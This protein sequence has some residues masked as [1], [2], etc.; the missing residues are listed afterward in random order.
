M[1]KRTVLR[2]GA[3]VLLLALLAGCGTRESVTVLREWEPAGGEE[4]VASLGA[5]LPRIGMVADVGGIDDESFN[6]GAW[7]GLL[8]LEK[9]TGAPVEY[10]TSESAED[11]QGNFE[12]LIAAG[13]RLTWGIGYEFSDTV[14]GEAVAHPELAFALVDAAYETTPDNVTCVVFRA[15]E[16]SFLV[17]YIAARTTKTGKIGFVGGGEGENIAAFQYGYM[18]G[19]AYAGAQSGRPPEV[20]VEYA[21]S[22]V[23]PEAGKRL[24]GEMFAAGCDVVYH[25]AGA[26]GIGVIQAAEEADAY[27]I[28]VDRDQASL[29]PEHVLTSAVKNVG[30][31]VNQVSQT[32][33]SGGAIGGRTLSFG[34]AE[35]AAGIPENHPLVDD[36]V[37]DDTLGVSDLIKAGDL[38]VPDTEEKYLEMVEE[39][40]ISNEQ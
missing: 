25:A 29:A 4:A 28:G 31:A 35:G 15:E 6:Q 19:A 34:L 24:A 17:G 20:L 7:E 10:R 9:A 2:L 23:D 33:L 5:E 27:A 11:F 39:L 37:Y 18:A 16:P 22:F 14:Q 36:Q 32:F 38:T 12:S 40:G 26:T 30:V 21:G 3:V 13:C 1:R 8:A